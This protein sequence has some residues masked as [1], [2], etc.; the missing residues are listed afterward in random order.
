[1]NHDILPYIFGFIKKYNKNICLVCRFWNEMYIQAT[2]MY[3][4]E[5]EFKNNITSAEFIKLMNLPRFSNSIN[6]NLLYCDINLVDINLSSIKI[7]KTKNYTNIEIMPVNILEELYL[8]YPYEIVSIPSFTRLKILKLENCGITKLPVSNTL[9]KLVIKSYNPIEIPNF[10]NL[11]IL[12][13]VNCGITKLPVNNILEVLYI[14]YCHKIT[15]IPSYTNLKVLSIKYCDRIK[16]ISV[17]N[18]VK[19]LII[20]GCG[21]L[22]DIPSFT[23]IKALK[24]SNNIEPL[25]VM[26]NF[27]RLVSLNIY[28]SDIKNLPIIN[29][30]EELKIEYCKYIDVL[31]NFT[32]LKILKLIRCNIMELPICNGLEILRIHD[33]DRITIIPSYT[34]LKSLNILCCSNIKEL[35]I[36]ITNT[37]EVLQLNMYRSPPKSYIDIIKNFTSD[38]M[39]TLYIYRSALRLPEF[40]RLKILYLVNCR[41]IIIPDICLNLDCT[42]IN[43]KNINIPKNYTKITIENYW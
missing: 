33:C 32:N 38:I 43:C 2:R 9:E 22:V 42:I 36:S 30:L 19:K 23:S 28:Y 40:T 27:N 1:M 18:T 37:L 15:I 41:N 6:L 12:K 13:L 21:N 8:N 10:T 7:F 35:P 17:N 24:Y 5:I 31:P 26:I 14:Q 34:N 29:T 39:D 11:K 20:Y 16:K 3:K 4:I 25:I